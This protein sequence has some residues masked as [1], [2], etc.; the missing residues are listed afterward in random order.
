MQINVTTKDQDQF[1]LDLQDYQ[2]DG[3]S[4]KSARNSKVPGM[5]YKKYYAMGSLN[6]FTSLN[7]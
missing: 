4:Y 7:N 2:S 1:M 3:R 5:G 6:C